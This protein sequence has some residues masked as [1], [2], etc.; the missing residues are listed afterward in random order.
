MTLPINQNGFR[1]CLILLVLTA[2]IGQVC[3][4]TGLPLPRFVSLRASEVNLRTGPGTRYPVEWVLIYRH[5]PVEIIAEFENWRKVREWQ[6]NI[7]WVHKSMLSGQRWV[8]VKK[9]KQDLRRAAKPDSPKIA[10]IEKKVIGRVEKCNTS[11][12]KIDFSGYTGWMRHNQ[13]W[14]VYPGE[15]IK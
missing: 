10:R 14:G 2:F 3:A 9:G 15:A 8:I 6:G 1:S 13:I 4:Q 11:W 12:C 7:G 5:M